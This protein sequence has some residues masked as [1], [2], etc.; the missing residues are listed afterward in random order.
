MRLRQCRPT[1][2]VAVILAAEWVAATFFLT[3]VGPTEDLQQT[4]MVSG[5]LPAANWAAITRLACWFWVVEGEGDWSSLQDGANYYSGATEI[6]YATVKNNWD[7]D[8]AARVGLAFDQALVYGKVGAVWG[9]FNWSFNYPAAALSTQADAILTG[10]L[11]GIG[12]EY[13]FTA[14]WIGRFE[15]DYEGFQTKD[16][17]VTSTSGRPYYQTLSADKNL[18]KV[19]LSYKY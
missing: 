19:A 1:A 14:N 17:F 2:G 3:R 12:L 16:I 8:I 13:A 15:Y 7:A 6:A 4:S 10:M 9:N 5:L 18:F 11:I